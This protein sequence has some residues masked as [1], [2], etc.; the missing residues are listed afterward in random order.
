M[1]KRYFAF[2][3]TVAAV[4]ALGCASGANDTDT[5]GAP[6]VHRSSNVI[7]EQEI[8]STSGTTAYEVVEKLHPEF[9]QTRG[10]TTTGS[11]SGLP[12]VYINSVRQGDITTLRNIAAGNVHEIHFY[13][14]AEAATKYGMQNP[15]GLNGI[16]EVTLKH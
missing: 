5:G 11:D 2:F 9:L 8:A 16:I 3:A 10:A 7:T 12:D 13:R 14:G 6:R 1:R 4:A 15:T